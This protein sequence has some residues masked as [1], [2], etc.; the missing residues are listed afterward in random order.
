MATRAQ[1]V[2]VGTFLAAS[3]ILLAISLA[4]SKGLSTAESIDL[5][6]EFPGSVSGLAPG[7]DV[8]YLG[9]PVGKV[10]DMHVS[11]QNNVV[12]RMSIRRKAVTLR[13]GVVASAELAGI[14]G[15]R[16]L[17]LSGGSPSGK[18]L[19]SGAVIPSEAGLLH[20]LGEELPQLVASAKR[21]FTEAEPTLV[22]ARA[23]FDE[24]KE[25]VVELR[26][27]A[28]SLRKSA[29]AI[30]STVGAA[31][32]AVK[33][34]GESIG[35]VMTESREKVAQLVES[36][37]ALAKRLK[38]QLGDVDVG[39][40]IREAELLAR[41]ARA[42]PRDLASTLEDLRS[43]VRK[44]RDLADLLERDPA[45]VVRGRQNPEAPPR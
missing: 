37:S 22:S 44:V 41:E 25:L 28:E 31:A 17:N 24:M 29:A 35:G 34:A 30:E 43:M 33:S 32:G 36:A 14:T 6:T 45:A 9:V 12:V 5:F 4:L 20:D 27:A 13:E 3:G 38:T 19:S 1:K 11:E 16:V 2:K 40:P 10:E 26:A 8:R 18:P 42:I 23:L 21:A 15:Y 7:A 39:L